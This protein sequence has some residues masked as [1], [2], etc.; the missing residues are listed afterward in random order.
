MLPEIIKVLSDRITRSGVVEKVFGLGTVYRLKDSTE[1]VVFENG[2]PVH[3]D[4]DQHKTLCFFLLN[5]P[6]S[7]AQRDNDVS[8]GVFIT[9]KVPLRLIYFSAGRDERICLPLHERDVQNII[10]L[11]AFQD[12][13]E[14][15]DEF[16]LSSVSFQV[17]SQEFRS[18]IV[19]AQIFGKLNYNLNETQQLFSIDFDLN[20]EGDP[21]CWLI[22][23]CATD[24][25]LDDENRQPMQNAT[26]EVIFYN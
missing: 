13:K 7:Q 17:T 5:G 25:I 6:V 2:Q 18:E 19:W 16:K 8:Y 3:I 26:G 11:L 24:K 15:R 20:F 9:K 14:L 22:Q 10:S 1:P 21:S 12:D 4:F 23:P